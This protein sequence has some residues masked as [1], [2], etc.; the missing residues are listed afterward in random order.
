MFTFKWISAGIPEKFP[1][2]QHKDT[3]PKSNLPESG[4]FAYLIR[5]QIPSPLHNAGHIAGTYLMFT[6]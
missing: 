2:Q 1:H 3:P 5:S 4:G 6:E